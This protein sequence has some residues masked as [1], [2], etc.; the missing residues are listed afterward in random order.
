VFQSTAVKGFDRRGLL[1]GAVAA[2][3]MSLLGACAT[4]RP[5]AGGLAFYDAVPELPPYRLHADRFFDI[6]ACLRPFRKAGPKFDVEQVAGKTVVYNYGHG[7]SGWSLSWGS[8]ELQ[9]K[10]ALA[11]SPTSIAVIG[12]G[13]LGLT[14]AI[15]ALRAGVPVTIY[16]KEVIH[17]ARSSRATGTWS[18]DS[19]VALAADAP[20]GFPALWEQ[21]ARSSFKTY[22]SYLGLPGNP[23]EFTDRYSL[24]DIPFAEARERREAEPSTTAASP[25]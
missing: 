16:A 2:G 18:P 9:V 17:Q 21:L 11:S 7:G 5:A 15:V 24:S 19:R 13:A 1:R 20:A 10:K 25:T 6:T 22:R 3:G 4:T 12:C 14:T 23:V 8:A